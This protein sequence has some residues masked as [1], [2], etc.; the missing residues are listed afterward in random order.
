[1]MSQSTSPCVLV[2]VEDGVGRVV[3]NRPERQNAWNQQMGRAYFAALEELGRDERVRVIV[4]SGAGGAFCSGGDA[5]VIGDIAEQGEYAL[6]ETPSFS[7]PLTVAKPI[8]ASIAG[9]CFGLGLVVALSCDIR[10]GGEGAK[11]STAYVRRGLSAEFGLSWTLPRVVGAGRAAE[12]LLS[13]R[14]VR[15]SEALQ[16]GLVSG[17]YADADLEAE[18][19]AYA[20]TLAAKCS[21][22]A[23]RL[24][25]GQLYTDLTGDLAGA[26]ARSAGLLEQAFG[27][28]DFAEGVASWRENRAPAFRPLPPDLA[29]IEPAPSTD[30]AD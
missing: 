29:Q 14:V 3:L 4:V 9:A 8:I 7:Y 23:M 21:P 20:R 2:S 13:G 25:K 5:E 17:V 28:G 11:F 16:M 12:L 30:S 24:I 26:Y 6:G 22:N 18:V 1:M 19:L 10:F 15:A 27:S